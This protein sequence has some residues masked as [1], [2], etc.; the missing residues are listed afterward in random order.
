MDLQRPRIR[1]VSEAVLVLAPKPGGFT[2]AELATQVCDLLPASEVTYTPR[3]A[4]YDLSKLR[5]KGLVE[6]IDKTRRYRTPPTGIRIL[7][8]PLILRKKVI[9]PVLAG[10]GNPVS[11]DLRKMSTLSTSTT[12]TSNV[13]CAVPLKRSH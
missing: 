2:V 7:A 11:A 12:T 9:K 8:G 10:L 3:H 1:A 13:S 6:R 5:G 4:S